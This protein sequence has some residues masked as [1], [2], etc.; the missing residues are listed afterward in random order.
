MSEKIIVKFAANLSKAIG[1]TKDESI[2]NLSNNR[3]E[4]FSVERFKN[5]I[6]EGNCCFIC[7]AKPQEIEFNDEHVFP[8]WLLRKFGLHNDEIHLPN[9]S[10]FKYGKFTIPCCSECNTLLGEQIEKPISKLV[11]LGYENIK[12]YLDNNGIS[13]I[14]NWLYLIFFKVHLKHKELRFNLDTRKPDHKISEMHDW[15]ELHHIHCMARA[16]YTKCNIDKDVYGS[17]IVFPAKSFAPNDDFDYA[18]LFHGKGIFIRIYDVCYIAILN[19]SFISLNFM[20]NFFINI[21]GHLSPLQIR[22]VFCRLVNI[23]MNLYERPEY[24]TNYDDNNNCTIRV[25]MPSEIK[26]IEPELYPLGNVLSYFCSDMVKK[27][28]EGKIDNLELILNNI[29]SGKWTFL[30]DETGKFIDA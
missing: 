5:D 24:Y 2:I 12:N 3:I 19:D 21:K 17:L 1:I 16:F 4:F 8:N 9:G 11:A 7:G 13:L 25:K 28:G 27:M 30:F 22:E 23:N 18:D 14:S 6:A 29:K 20:Y 15:T 26:L 10:T